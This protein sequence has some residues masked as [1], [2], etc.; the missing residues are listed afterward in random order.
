MFQADVLKSDLPKELCPNQDAY[1]ILKEDWQT[2][3]KLAQ[4]TAQISSSDSVVYETFAPDHPIQFRP[5]TDAQ[6]EQ[7][8]RQ[9]NGFTVIYIIFYNNILLNEP[10]DVDQY[11]Y[12]AYRCSIV[13]ESSIHHD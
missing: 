10:V 2:Y 3:L 13:I 6:S 9:V 7:I 8:R 12:S 4:Q 1:Q 11:R 5:L